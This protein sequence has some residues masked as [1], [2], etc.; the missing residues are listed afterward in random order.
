MDRFRFSAD[1]TVISV[2]R[3]W[4]FTDGR[5]A[6]SLERSLIAAHKSDRYRGPLILRSGGNTELFVR[7]ILQLDAS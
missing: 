7:D 1:K 4:N 2:L 6:W 5:D 3:E